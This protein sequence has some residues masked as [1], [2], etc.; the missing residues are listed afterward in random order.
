[1]NPGSLITSIVVDDTF[2]GTLVID[3]L[4]SHAPFPPEAESLAFCTPSTKIRMAVPSY[5]AATCCHVLFVKTPAGVLKKCWAPPNQ[6]TNCSP[7]TPISW[8]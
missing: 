2:Y 4:L 5:V 6:R 7:F 1:M 3:N 8:E